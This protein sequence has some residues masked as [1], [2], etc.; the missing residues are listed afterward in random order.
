MADS[1]GII[2]RTPLIAGNWKMNKTSASGAEFVRRLVESI[3]SVKD[4]EVVVAPPFS[5]LFE[6]VR[7]ASGSS[8]AIAAQ[9]VFWEKE[10]AFTGEV[11]VEMLLDLGVSACIVGH[12]ERR[13]YF[14]ETDETVSKKVAAVVA[15]GMLPIMCVGE[16]EQQRED[17][18]TEE[19][20]ARQVPAGLAS[21]SSEAACDVCIAYEPI[22]AIGT[23]RTA[24][25]DIAQLA[26]GFVRQQVADTLGEAAAQRVRILYGG[27]VTP[28][29]VDEL[30]AQDDID[31]ALVGGAS[32]K[33]DSFRRIVDFLPV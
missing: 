17:G 18:L 27:S 33:I 10:G 28:D 24:T 1:K 23:G 4:R 25:P 21:V 20:L 30:M 3:G 13:Q 11:S 19:V 29:N 7:E 26:I 2:K 22:W 9:D 6:A 32:L 8:I 15:A 31:G 5:G 14:G 16:N 12:S